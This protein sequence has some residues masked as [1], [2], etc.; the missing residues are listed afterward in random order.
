[1]EPQKK[2]PKNR[3][4]FASFSAVLSQQLLSTEVIMFLLPR[5]IKIKDLP[6]KGFRIRTDLDENFLLFDSEQHFGCR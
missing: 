5:A 3:N 2:L 4:S 6:I 1:M